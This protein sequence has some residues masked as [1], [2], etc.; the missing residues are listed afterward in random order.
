M[1]NCDSAQSDKRRRS[2]EN[3]SPLEGVKRSERLR[4]RRVHY[5]DMVH[6]LHPRHGE[7]DGADIETKTGD[8]GCQQNSHHLAPKPGTGHLCLESSVRTG[9]RAS[10][11]E[12]REKLVA[13]PVEPLQGAAP[14]N[15][16]RRSM[17]LRSSTDTR[18]DEVAVKRDAVHPLTTGLSVAPPGGRRRPSGL[19][20]QQARQEDIP[21][22]T[23]TSGAA[24]VGSD[25]ER[26]AD[27]AAAVLN[28]R[29]RGSSRHRRRMA[30]RRRSRLFPVST[31]LAD[32]SPGPSAPTSQLNRSSDTDC[33]QQTVATI[34]VDEQEAHS[35][36]ESVEFADAVDAS[37]SEVADDGSCKMLKMDSVIVQNSVGCDE[38]ENVAA[39]TLPNKT[40]VSTRILALHASRSD[41]IDSYRVKAETPPLTNLV[42]VM[43][44]DFSNR[45]GRP[46][47]SEDGV[48][49][50]DRY[51]SADAACVHCC[52]CSELFSVVEFIRHMHHESRVSVGSVRRLGP[53]G[54]A[55]PEWHEF[56]RRRAE[57]AV[58]ISSRTPV[59]PPPANK[60]TDTTILKIDI[61]PAPA[62]NLSTENVSEVLAVDEVG[63][64]KSLENL[65]LAPV[66]K[67]ET[68]RSGKV[69]RQPSTPVSGQHTKSAG[70]ENSTESP[71]PV[72]TVEE[73]VKSIGDVVNVSFSRPQ[74]GVVV[75]ASCPAAV[76]E[77]SAAPEPRVTR[78]RH[79][80]V[81][82]AKPSPGKTSVRRQ[83]G[84]VENPNSAPR[85]SERSCKR[86]RV[87]S[88]T[89]PTL[90]GDSGDGIGTR[91]ELRPRQPPRTTAPK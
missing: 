90:N 51:I 87:D 18:T 20:G 79:A 75:P 12:R 44:V 29:R 36:V 4:D 16:R 62:V 76:E 85:H 55:G 67:E 21:H 78:S 7:A 37:V 49:L 68:T 84:A 47:R 23:V 8:T 59:N 52:S 71:P 58:G 9:H 46:Q 33:S 72:S 41:G 27:R 80:S 77:T 14:A 86:V 39:K 73:V 42:P 91:L 35:T 57:F 19:G 31:Q 11:T 74:K 83:S 66:V 1:F 82:H 17:E 6:G 50:L 53:R 30:A 45:V 81:G 69:R 56:Q 60:F 34:N 15:C 65:P 43:H 5:V 64:S 13:A 88:A 70:A 32:P 40:S 22:A 38:S 89:T 3:V 10:S 25:A 61:S 24:K 26:P 28:R 2:A 63:K 54:G 48:V